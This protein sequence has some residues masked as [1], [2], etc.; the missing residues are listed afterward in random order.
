MDAMVRT[1]LDVEGRA[2]AEVDP[3]RP[4][5]ADLPGTVHRFS[6]SWRAR[7]TLDL[8]PD[9]A[10]RLPR[11]VDQL[12]HHVVVEA[13]TN[14]RRH[15]SG[16]AEVVVRLRT[17]VGPALEVSVTDGGGAGSA[18]SVRR[19]LGGTGLAELTDR[20]GAA[21]GRLAAGRHGPGWRVVASL[22]LP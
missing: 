1:L 16:S 18:L 9:L 10:G 4:G 19:D 3:A 20:V 8:A 15:A 7:T 13:L 14:I 17:V 2:T 21:G 11:A 22:P 12:A 5:V 6:A